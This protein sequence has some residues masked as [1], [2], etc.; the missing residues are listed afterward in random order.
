MDNVVRDKEL[1]I[2]WA[3]YAYRHSHIWSTVYKITGAVAAIS[4]LPYLEPDVVTHLGLAV[5]SL[6]LIGITITL[7]GLA[8]IKGELKLFGKTK[9]RYREIQSQELHIDH[10]TT[11]KFNRDVMLYMYFLLALAVVNGVYLLASWLKTTM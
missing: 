3:E 1:G 8:R 10:E 4:L 6:P 9:Q 2:L 7:L 5:L 11:G